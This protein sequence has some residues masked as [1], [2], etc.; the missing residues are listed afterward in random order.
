MKDKSSHRVI[1]FRAWDGKEMIYDIGVADNKAADFNE[2]SLWFW[3]EPAK[4]IMQFIGLPDKHGK[5]IYEGDICRQTFNHK[6]ITGEIRISPTQGCLVGLYPLWPHD[7]EIIG[8]VYE[9][10]D[11]LKE[12]K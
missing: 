7:I 1:K 10:P 3:H 6:T 8:N 4:A 5:E 12:K 2:E 9:N 11:L